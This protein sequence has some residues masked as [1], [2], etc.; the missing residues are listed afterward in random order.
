MNRILLVLLA[1]AAATPSLSQRKYPELNGHVNDF[2]GVVPDDLERSLEAELREFARTSSMEIAVAVVQTLNGEEPSD[3]TF[4]M[5]EENGIGKSETDNGVLVM[6]CPPERAYW[7]TT[8]YGMEGVLPD[9]RVAQLQRNILLPKLKQDRGAEGLAELTRAIRQE[10]DPVAVEQRAAV[11]SARREKEAADAEEA[12]ETVL[13]VLAVLAVIGGIVALLVVSYRRQKRKER[14]KAEAVERWRDLASRAAAAVVISRKAAE[15]GHP[16]A[17]SLGAKVSA[18]VWPEAPTDHTVAAFSTETILEKVGEYVGVHDALSTAAHIE[19]ELAAASDVRR[20]RRTLDNGVETVRKQTKEARG[21]RDRVLAKWPDAA[22]PPW[23]EAEMDRGASETTA[24]AIKMSNKAAGWDIPSAL[25]LLALAGRLL[26]SVRD[27]NSKMI[28]AA[29]RHESS[30]KMIVSG[31][32][33]EILGKMSAAALASSRQEGVSSSTADLI[34]TAVAAANAWTPTGKGGPGGDYDRAMVLHSAVKEGKEKAD[35][36]HAALVR[37][38]REAQEEE[39]RR[40]RQRSSYSPSFGGGSFGSSHSSGGFGGFGGG[41]S[42]GG[43][44]GGRY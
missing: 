40:R 38:R 7:T 13:M 28:E 20:E 41:R 1:L 33:H 44:A 32:L 37:R 35:G 42:G 5:F 16:L 36:E 11:E 34:K 17:A 10:L 30:H 18:A 12:K 29:A 22:L 2:V 21:A 14:A 23:D 26:R 43:G 15:H 9:A 4:G 19:K 25:A 24:T 8:G 31:K 27:D 39:D 6:W 3:Y